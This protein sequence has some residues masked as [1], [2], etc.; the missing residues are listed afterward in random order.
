M[1][2]GAHRL[3]NVV[4]LAQRCL[5]SLAV[6]AKHVFDFVLVEFL[7]FVAGRTQIFARV[8]FCGL[9]VEHLAY[10]SRHSQTRVGVDVDFAYGAL[11]E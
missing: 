1:Q 3:L 8:E 11:G 9:V 2:D 4:C 5:F 7:H 10:H 6:G